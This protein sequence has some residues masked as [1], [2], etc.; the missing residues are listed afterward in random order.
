M[1]RMQQRASRSRATLEGIKT[2][3]EE[4]DYDDDGGAENKSAIELDISDSDHRTAAIERR[5]EDQNENPIAPAPA[6]QGSAK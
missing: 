4:D 1:R 2:H 6:I 3:L 5:R